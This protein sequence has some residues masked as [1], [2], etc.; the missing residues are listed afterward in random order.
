VHGRP[1][2]R[3][4]GTAVA[5]TVAIVDRTAGE[6]TSGGAAML[7]AVTPGISRTL[8]GRTSVWKGAIA[9]VAKAEATFNR[10]RRS[11]SALPWRAIRAGRALVLA[12]V[13]PRVTTA[14]CRRG[15]TV[16]ERAVALIANALAGIPAAQRYG[17]C[18]RAGMLTPVPPNAS[19]AVNSCLPTGTPS[20]VPSSAL[21]IEGGGV[22]APS[23]GIPRGTAGCRRGCVGRDAVAAVWGRRAPWARGMALG[24]VTT[25]CVVQE[26]AQ[27]EDHKARHLEAESDHCLEAKTN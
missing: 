15:A 23:T 18:R 7:T 4:G 19:R 8:A 21:T 16:W 14:V 1:L 27:E 3:A 6:G 24:A 12:P 9:L 2:V 26:G 10:T 25:G 5:D 11:N 20:N 17:T 22:A 13:T